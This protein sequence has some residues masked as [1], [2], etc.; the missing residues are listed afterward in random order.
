MACQTSGVSFGDGEEGAGWVGELKRA[1]KECGGGK[2]VEEERRTKIPRNHMR[3]DK[4][5]EKVLA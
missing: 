5:D 1:M 2:S 4:D 3:D